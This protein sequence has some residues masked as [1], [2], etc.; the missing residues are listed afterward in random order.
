MSDLLKR[1]DLLEREVAQLT[2]ERR[3]TM[4]TLEMAANLL[5]FVCE[6]GELE[7]VEHVLEE[8][9]GKILS[10]LS[11]E[12][13]CFYLIDERDASFSP[14]HCEPSDY[15]PDFERRIDQLIEDQTFAWA[16]GRNK[17]VRVEGQENEPPLLLHAISTA[18]RTRG[19]FIGIPV[20]GGDEF[21]SPLPLL[22][23]VLHS[24]ANIIES[25]ELYRHM[26]QKNQKL[27][28]KITLLE[29]EL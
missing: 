8:T 17:P 16:L 22:T 6:P 19:M 13:L 28:E 3:F 10:M 21:E 25:I 14:V 11:F 1:I 18:S 24:C 15:Q 4:S 7:S 12:A 27:K 2:E 23:L 9:A 20:E 29:Q 5:T 26:H